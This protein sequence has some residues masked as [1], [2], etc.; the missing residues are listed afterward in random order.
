MDM[1]KKDR[2]KARI[3]ALQVMYSCEAN[4]TTPWSVVFEDV[5]EIPEMDIS[6]TDVVKFSKSLLDAYFSNAEYIDGLITK[7]IKNW[8]IERLAAIDR[9]ILRLSLAEL[10]SIKT[11]IKVVIS[12]AV[13]IAK[14]YGTDDSGKFVNGVL[15]ATKKD[16]D[17]TE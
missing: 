2:R 14:E 4:E 3:V 12:E 10:I 5:R 11:P 13:D 9:N 16:I 8:V 1:S 7:N 15:D 17:Y 6:S